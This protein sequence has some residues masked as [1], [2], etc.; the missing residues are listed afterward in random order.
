M[1][2][3][4]S[5]SADTRRTRLKI[6]RAF[7]AAINAGRQDEAASLLADDFVMSDAGG[8]NIGRDCFL[9]RDRK[10][11]Q[12]YGNPQIAIEQLS[13]SGGQVLMTG[14]ID[15]IYEAVGGPILCRLLV[16]EGI[17]CRIEVMRE[18]GLLTLAR[19]HPVKAS[20]SAAAHPA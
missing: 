10:F 14:H 1:T 8:S 6:V 9:E 19:F 11:R 5:F 20:Q 12:T 2:W 17:I 3:P 18:G 13:D 15:S 7:F 4:F 16:R